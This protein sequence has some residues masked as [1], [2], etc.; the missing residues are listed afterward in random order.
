LFSFF[1]TKHFEGGYVGIPVYRTVVLN[2]MRR[3]DLDFSIVLSLESH[4]HVRISIIDSIVDAFPAV[5]LT[6][7]FVIHFVHL[8]Y[9][10]TKISKADSCALPIPAE[11]VTLRI[12]N[13]A[14]VSNTFAAAVTT[15][16]QLP[17]LQLH[18]CIRNNW[19]A[20]TYSNIHWSAFSRSFKK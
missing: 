1:K 11:R 9:M 6:Y 7:S 17:S 15:A 18:Q 5:L 8:L 20:F 13:A 4:R 16:H 10:A 2:T 12:A 19:T 14:I 3:G